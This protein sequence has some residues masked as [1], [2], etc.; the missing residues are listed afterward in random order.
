MLYRMMPS[1]VSDVKRGLDEKSP[2]ILDTAHDPRARTVAQAVA[3]IQGVERVLLFG[4]RA[5]GDHLPHSD[6]DLLVVVPADR[7]RPE[8]IEDVADRAVRRGYGN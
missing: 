7:K 6:I 2:R 3:E 1:P 5:R 4:S 8:A